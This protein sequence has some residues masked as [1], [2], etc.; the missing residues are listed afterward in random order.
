MTRWQRILAIAAGLVVLAGLYALRPDH[1]PPR[2]AFVASADAPLWS[3][4]PNMSA[5]ENA[6]HHWRKH[7][8]EFPQLHSAAEYEAAAHAFVSA[9]PPGTLVKHHRNGDTLFYDPTRNTFAV[10]ARNGAPRTMFKPDNGMRY[11]ERQ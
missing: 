7:G 1:G 6:E 11:W 10:R 8:R 4:T 5:T 9:P 2:E 3:S